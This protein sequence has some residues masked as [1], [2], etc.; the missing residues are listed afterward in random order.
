[1]SAEIEAG[2]VSGGVQE[3]TFRKAV[4]TK[5]ATPRL[6]ALRQR[7]Q[8][9]S[10]G[11]G[12]GKP[13]LG[14]ALTRRSTQTCSQAWNAFASLGGPHVHRV[15]AANVVTATSEMLAPLP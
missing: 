14:Q 6:A 8:E 2:E 7:V 10:E 3:Y 5:G 13:T 15:N 4:G 9:L 12:G 11:N 1:I